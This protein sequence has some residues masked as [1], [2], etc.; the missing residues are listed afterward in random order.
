MHIVAAAPRAG[1]GVFRLEHGIC[2]ITEIGDHGFVSRVFMV[3]TDVFVDL[4]HGLNCRGRFKGIHGG[5]AGALARAIVHHGNVR[6][7]AANEDGV[8]AH[9][10]S[11]MI[12]LIDDHRG[13]ESNARNELVSHIADTIERG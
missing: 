3:I 1:I 12:H 2:R 9:M 7:K 8:I 5:F 6:L 4:V 13:N 11:M 10:E